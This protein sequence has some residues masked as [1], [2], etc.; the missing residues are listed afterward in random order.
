[1]IGIYRDIKEDNITFVASD[2]HKLVRFVNNRLKPGITS[3]F[4]LPS[5]PASILNGIIG[6]C[7]NDVKIT[8]D[9][10]SATFEA[11]NFSL[12]CR[13]INGRYP[14]YNSVIP[15]N[16]PFEITVDRVS[17]LNAVK[18]VSVFSSAGG[19][20]RF[21]ISENRMKLTAD[22]TGVLMSDIVWDGET[23]EASTPFATPWRGLMAAD[24]IGGLQTRQYL[25]MNLS[26]DCRIADTTWIVPGQMM[27]E[28]R[29]S[30]ENTAA[31]IDFAVKMGVSYLLYDSGWY[32]TE[33]D[34]A[35]NPTKPVVGSFPYLTRPPHNTS[36][37]TC[38]VDVRDAV[39][40]ARRAG[41]G[42]VLYV[43][44]LHLELYDLDEMFSTYRK[45][46]VAGVKF[47]FVSI[48]SQKWTRWLV[49][50]IATAAKY[51]LFVVIH[52]EYIP[53]GLER[54]YPNI[55]NIE[56]VYGDEEAPGCVEDLKSGFTRPILGPT[57]HTF[58]YPPDRFK[59][60]GRKTRAFSLALPLLF[61]GAAP[62]PYWYAVPSQ[63]SEE[64]FPELALWRQMPVT[65]DESLSLASSF[66]AYA[67]LA[68]RH[69][70]IWYVACLSAVSRRARIGLEF[71]A[72]GTQYHAEICTDAPGSTLE[73]NCVVRDSRTVTRES[74][75]DFSLVAG[76][77]ALVRL[78]PLTATPLK[79]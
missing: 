78:V 25:L 39:K 36:I 70:D 73:N 15:Q 18:R 14:N 71:L 57:D 7:E 76:G 30:P 8:F 21:D 43:N 65:W 45:W 49:R 6:K 28:A 58:C 61:Y 5:K 79:S 72:P 26:E 69:G 29:L 37:R 1:M 13:F 52:D 53:S 46:G 23:V 62:S 68:R 74:V 64:E 44:H 50:A 19:L 47:G 63:C 55:L 42:V 67:D 60:Q 24:S 22:G 32:G 9:S 66:G 34:P 10:K 54:T 59:T 27:R 75:L 16:N 77:G 12:T 56:G 51:Q 17:L 35:M 20:V 33:D 38:G 4:I 2:T 40:A 11:D 31:C 3:S 41:V 48:G